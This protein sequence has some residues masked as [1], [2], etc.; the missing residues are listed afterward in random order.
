MASNYSDVKN[1]LHNELGITKE[2]V[3]EVIKDTVK[4]EISVLMGDECFIRGL[5]EKE[6]LGCIGRKDSKNWHIIHDCSNWISEEINN[7]ILNEV[8][9]KLEIRLKDDSSSMTYDELRD[10][11]ADYISTVDKED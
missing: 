2:Y 9:N 8:K 3:E 6:V 4:K 11:F 10:S 5:V 7:V 1:F